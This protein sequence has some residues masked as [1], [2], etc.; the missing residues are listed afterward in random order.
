MAV[1]PI[2]QVDAFTA[3][4]FS[5][6]PAAVV[7][8][9]K[10]LSDE[11][12]LAIAAEN[13]LAETA[14]FVPEGDGYRLRWFT[15]T[16]EVDLCGHATLATAY[17][18][19]EK[20]GVERSKLSFETRSGRLDVDRDGDWLVMSF[21]RWQLETRA[22]PD[23]VFT[24]VIGREPTELYSTADG[25]IL[26]AVLD[27]EDDV[28]ESDPDCRSFH[29]LEVPALIVTAPGRQSDCV[30]RFF[31]PGYGIPE[32]AGTGSIHCALV[33]YWSQRL[34]RNEIHSR[35]ISPRGAE[36]RCELAGNRVSL[37]GQAAHYMTGS[38]EF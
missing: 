11:T 18:L 1:L 19:F 17:V 29:K 32:D 7:P 31:A 21:P 12:M 2:Y 25:Q 4:R 33:P 34:G 16:F 9:E 28:A 14:F 24:S 38:I 6:N 3:R 13:N 30:C 27:G 35:Q 22:I 37:A 20:L 36:L 8:L 5:G 10:W 26:L 15:P 23:S